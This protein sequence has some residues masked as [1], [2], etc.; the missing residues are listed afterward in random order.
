MKITPRAP[1]FLGAPAKDVNREMIIRLLISKIQQIGY[2]RKYLIIFQEVHLGDRLDFLVQT[3]K[4]SNEG[5]II[6]CYQALTVI[7]KETP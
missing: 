4:Q 6:C 3:N 5:K 2:R 1:G 7:V